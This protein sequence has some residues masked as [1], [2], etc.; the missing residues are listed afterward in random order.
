MPL[1][2]ALGLYAERRLPTTF[3]GKPISMRVPWALRGELIVPNGAPGVSF[4]DVF[5]LAIDKPFEIHRLRAHVYPFNDAVTPLT[6]PISPG[7]LAQQSLDV[8]EI[9]D[10]FI[11]I[12]I[13]DISKNEKLTRVPTLI[14]SLMTQ[15]R[16]TWEW[17]DPY[18]IVRSEGFQVDVDNLA[19]VT[20]PLCFTCPTQGSEICANLSVRL[21]FEGYL[22]IIAPPSETR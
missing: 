8:R 5:R 21:A 16:K 11:R 3:A 13:T 14:K 19:P 6:A 2:Q 7:T 17:E 1:E 18:T 12:D 10:D 4:P 22:L 9:L 20:F 15:D